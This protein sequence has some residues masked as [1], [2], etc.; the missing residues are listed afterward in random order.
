[1]QKANQ[2]AYLRALC[3][4]AVLKFVKDFD[5]YILR[6]LNPSIGQNIGVVRLF[7][8]DEL[9]TNLHLHLEWTTMS[10]IMS[11]RKKCDLS[12]EKVQ[13]GTTSCLFLLNCQ[14][15]GYYIGT[16]YSAKMST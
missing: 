10:K 2:N 6:N 4:Y 12:Q 11:K 9:T 5:F 13:E 7:L 1:M 3:V 8:Y 14:P 15:F 16:V